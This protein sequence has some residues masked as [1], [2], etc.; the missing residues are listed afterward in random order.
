MEEKRQEQKNGRP[1]VSVVVPVYNAASFLERT[2][3]SIR[4]QTLQNIEILLVD[5]GSKDAS[6]EV[7][8]SLARK[9][10]RIRTF[11]E[12][13]GGA[14][15]A[16]NLGIAGAKGRYIGFVDSDD[17]IGP[18]MY[19]VL[20]EGARRAEEKGHRNFIVQIGREE[21]DEN[22]RPLP[23]AVVPPVEPTWVSAA[24]FAESLLLYT[25]D[26]SF[27]T[28]LLPAAYMKAHPFTEGC[29][30]EDFRLLMEMADLSL[31]G[32]LRLPQREYRVVHRHGSATRQAAPRQFS[33]VY[34]DI[35][36][37]ADYVEQEMTVRHP[38][39]AGPAL[40]FGLYE[41]LDYLL[42]VP[43]A[44]MTEENAFYQDVI[45]YLRR[46]FRRM[47]RCPG[48]TRKNRMYLTLL[49]LA[50]KKT[51]QLH[52]LLRRRAIERSYE[53]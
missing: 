35:V 13:N 48:L 14:A 45:R 20:L 42:H 26:A 51:R 12:E 27:C 50:P 25:G 52:W 53:K 38:A 18:E 28:S 29:M 30:G 3:E 5:D 21:E 15:R 24:S 19:A 7:C 22:G 49:T 33:R 34:V 23:D 1:L 17:L 10:P 44:D 6:Y 31:E 46:N 36:R 2:V 16:R 43:I 39:L 37:H 41:R 8:R 4:N 32:V 9:D 40:R 47:L 11:T